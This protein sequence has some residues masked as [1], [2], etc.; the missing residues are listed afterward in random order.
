MQGVNMFQRR[1][2][3]CLSLISIS[4]LVAASGLNSSIQNTQQPPATQTAETKATQGVPTIEQILEKYA[5]TIGGKAALQATTSRV[6]KGV[7]NVPSIGAKGTIE[8]YAKAPNKELTDLASPILGTSRIGFNGHIAWREENGEVKE[9]PSYPKREADFYLL[10]KLREIYPKIELKGKEKIGNAEA[11]RLE[12]PR[13]GNPKR[14]YFD[15]ETG[16]LLRTEVR[17]PQGKLL[18]REDY[19][20]YRAVDGIKVPLTMRRIEQDEIEVIIK[21]SEVKFN[22]PIEDAKFEKPAAQSSGQV[23]SLQSSISLAM[24]P[25]TR[26]RLHQ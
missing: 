21:F 25:K 26:R 20:D 2:L 8:I 14:W 1:L 24:T 19:E 22:V 16:L 12:A 7:I 18:S 13:L 15:A 9:L 4:H 3:I 17:S 11:Y 5:K 10:I 23:A 6:M